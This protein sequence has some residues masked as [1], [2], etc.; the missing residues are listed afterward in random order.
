MLLDPKFDGWASPDSCMYNCQ[1]CLKV[2]DSW[3]TEGWLTEVWY[4]KPWSVPSNKVPCMY[5]YIY[6]FIYFSI[7]YLIYNLRIIYVYLYNMYTYIYIYIFL[8]QNPEHYRTPNQV[9]EILGSENPCPPNSTSHV[10]RQVK[11]GKSSKHLFF[12]RGPCDTTWKCSKFLKATTRCCFLLARASKTKQHLEIIRANSLLNHYWTNCCITQP[13]WRL[14]IHPSID[15]YIYIYKYPSQF[16]IPGDRCVKLLRPER[17]CGEPWLG[18]QLVGGQSFS[19]GMNKTHLTKKKIWKVTFCHTDRTFA[20][21]VYRCFMIVSA[22]WSTFGFNSYALICNHHMDIGHHILPISHK[23]WSFL[24]ISPDL[25][26]STLGENHRSWLRGLQSIE[27]LCQGVLTGRKFGTSPKWYWDFMGFQC[28]NQ[29]MII[30]Q[31]PLMILGFQYE[32]NGGFNN[33]WY[34][35]MFDINVSENFICLIHDILWNWDLN[36]F[37]F[38]ETA[39]WKFNERKC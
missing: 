36:N 32:N 24:P 13:C 19:R 23:V 15:I 39:R 28:V 7:Y 20:G 9:W 29:R 3:W 25:S 2:G 35:H 38:A 30:S 10:R 34:S 27:G 5:I 37:E 4:W 6:I 16:H 22:K 18:G 11:W 1:T 33:W 12:E 21:L 14:S 17:L 31:C 26:V 8:N